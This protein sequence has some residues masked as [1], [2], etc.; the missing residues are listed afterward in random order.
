MSSPAANTATID[1]S[2]VI[3][4]WNTKELL[5]QLLPQL[6]PPVAARYHI[7]VIVVDNASGDGSGDAVREH[8]PEVQLL[9]QTQNGGFA[10]GVN[11]GAAAARGRYAML[12]NSDTDVQWAAIERFLA[13]ADAQPDGMV[14]GPR[15]TDENGNVQLTAWMAARPIDYW[16][17]AVIPNFNR[18]APGPIDQ[19]HEVDCVSGCAFLIR[20]DAL[21]RLGG[22]DERFFMYFEEADYCQRVRQVGGAVW[23]LP[24]ATFVHHGGLSANKAKKRTF[25]ALQE[26]CLL[27]HVVWHGRWATEC[28]R[29][30]L[31]CGF[32]LRLCCALLLRLVGRGQRLG[33]FWAA[34]MLLSR[35]G[36]VAALARRPRLVPTLTSP[37]G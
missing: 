9:P 13:D 18:P 4:N 34:V 8:H 15:V 20:R 22:L 29:L 11:R 6:R 25:L 28:V 33:L 14:F 7:E 35:P 2:I 27:Y 36:L 30:A 19:D 17:G 37:T 5:L 26:S 21:E 12:L 3:V 23:F 31:L 32:A 24:G 16:F 1:L 10:F